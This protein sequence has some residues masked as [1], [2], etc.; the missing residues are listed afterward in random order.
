MKYNQIL[1]PHFIYSQYLCVIKN[2]K[3][4]RKEVDI[5]AYLLSGRSAKSIGYFLSISHKTVETHTRNVMKKL[6]CNSREAII[7]FIEKSGKLSLLKKHHT[8]LLLLPEFEESLKSISILNQ[9]GVLS[10][11]IVY[12]NDHESEKTFID[13]IETHLKLA[14]VKTSLENRDMQTSL[15]HLIS[16]SHKEDYVI[17]VLPMASIEELECDNDESL[18][19]TTPGSN[20]PLFL[21]P[22]RES[23]RKIPKELIPFDCIDHAE[24][25]NYYFLVFDI[26]RKL[27]INRNLEKIISDF[28]DEYKKVNE[29]AE[30]NL[31]QVISNKSKPEKSVVYPLKWFLLFGLFFVG[32]MGCGFLALQWDQNKK[33]YSIRSDLVLPTESILL[34]RPKLLAQIEAGFKERGRIISMALVGLGGSGKT[35]LVRQY[36]RQ[37]KENVIWEI[38]AETSESLKA[39]FEK[40]A[41]LLARSDEDQKIVKG[42]QDIKNP[43]ERE[44]KIIQF[45][46]DRLKLHSNWLLIYDN[47]QNFTVIQK[48]FPQ[49]IDT[50]GQGK[51]I[52]TTQDSNIQNNKYINHVI[53]IRELDA[54][55]KLNLFMKIMSSGN[56]HSFNST[57]KKEAKEFLKK[58]PPFPLDVAVAA[59][60][61]KA[62]NISYSKYLER[63]NVYTN[64]FSNMQESLLKEAGDYVKT[65]Y[66][67]ITLSLKQIMDINKDFGD[68]MLF[69]SLLDSQSIPRDLLDNYKTEIIVDEFIHTLKK[70]SLITIESSNPLSS[71]PSISIHRNTRE[72][73]LAYLVRVLKLE[74]NNPLLQSISQTLENYI[75][76]VIE[77]EDI[78]KMKPL[79]GHIN[80]FLSH[81]DF[82]IDALKDSIN[83]GLGCIYFFLGDYIK[84]KKLLEGSLLSLNK[85][86]NENQ[87]RIAQ[88]LVYLG[89]FHREL[90][91]YEKAHEL[92]E[93]SYI[94]YKKDGFKDHNGTARVLGLLGYVYREQG[95]Y[96]KAKSLLEQSLMTYKKYIPDNHVRTAWISILLGNVYW[97]FGNY[98]KAKQLL[99]DS[100]IVLKNNLTGN[101]IWIFWNLSLLGNV[102]RDLGNYEKAKNLLE[103]S[104]TLNQGSLPKDHLWSADTLASLGNVYRNLRYYKKATDSLEHS[105]A[106]Y[107]K[108]LPEDH[109]LII[110]ASG[111][112]GNVYRD[113]GKYE[114]A[115]IIQER[116]LTICEKLYGKDSIDT[117]QISKNLG[118]IFLLEGKLEKAETFLHKAFIIFQQNEHPKGYASLENLAELYIKKSAL[119]ENKRDLHQSQKLKRLAIEYLNQALE[120]AK[121]HFPKN[122][123][124]LLRIQGKLQKLDHE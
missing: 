114:K 79:I 16:E 30:S 82:F 107:K 34:H 10:C 86:Y 95:N 115:R 100:Y 2:I 33:N 9:E 121:T 8:S 38:N 11:L 67:I 23:H 87:S 51:V 31:T 47:V 69:I 44:E 85:N 37:H 119:F 19:K 91:D 72:I 4:T 43:V 24:Q 97:K 14:G 13:Q 6:G 73:S 22:E 88:N 25:K 78:L 56:I 12:W 5:I 92:L 28:E 18:P 27:F 102:Y 58:I 57:H 122:S 20:H 111:N 3:F 109:I 42:F 76:T 74:K 66:S 39:S 46:K 120:I 81:N 40:L 48:Y 101:H 63:L 80:I 70:Y 71:T 96:E 84:A 117:A 93:K 113:L 105:L 99:E 112:L 35:T 77:Q 62:T 55:E 89:N 26:L 54:G 118:M 1:L 17:Y 60:Y 15:A 59:Y 94:I 7:N 64:N 36:A 65:R 106:I 61:L 21:L 124:H 49:N 110:R 123:P 52:L 50:W 90:G 41:G 53:Q 108:N 32:L 104:L 103:E 83:G 45:V 116:A 98:K 29:F 68:L 75:A